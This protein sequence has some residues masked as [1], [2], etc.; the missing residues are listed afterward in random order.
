MYF[1]ILSCRDSKE[2]KIQ[3]SYNFDMTSKEAF[4]TYKAKISQYSRAQFREE[5]MD[6]SYKVEDT[7]G[8]IL[9]P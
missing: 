9:S 8:S 4:L 2:K 3:V 7:E 6:L 5:I 1:K